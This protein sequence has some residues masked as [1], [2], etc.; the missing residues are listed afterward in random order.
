MSQ[1]EDFS[2][3]N[4]FIE[5]PPTAE[6]EPRTSDYI[7]VDEVDM[8]MTYDDL[9]TYGVLRKIYNLGPVS[10]FLKICAQ[11]ATYLN[12]LEVYF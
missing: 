8:G 11:S 2:F 12:P 3:L 7:Q 6:L 9:S 5:A 4:E 10:M 1:E